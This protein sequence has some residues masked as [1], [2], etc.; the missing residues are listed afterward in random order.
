MELTT[1]PRCQEVDRAFG[2]AVME[3][4]TLTVENTT[5]KWQS[6]SK[7]TN[8]RSLFNMRSNRTYKGSDITIIDLKIAYHE[9]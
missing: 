3:Y 4:N 8:H 5:L 6:H 9:P 1:G 2:S 7:H